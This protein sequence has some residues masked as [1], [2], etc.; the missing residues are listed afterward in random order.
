MAR[1]RPWA[2]PRALALGTYPISRATARTISR[3]EALTFSGRRNANETVAMET[4][5]R[6]A[7]SYTVGPFG[8]IHPSNA[9]V[10]ALIACSLAAGEC[11]IGPDEAGPPSRSATAARPI[12]PAAR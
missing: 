12:D 3:V 2:N 6:S 5:A 10:Y 8:I 11:E 7:T 9:A 1:V 4:P